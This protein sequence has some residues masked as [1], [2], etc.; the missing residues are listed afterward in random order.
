M[1]KLREAEEHMGDPDT[2]RVISQF[3]RRVAGLPVEVADAC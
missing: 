1:K 2:G 3:T